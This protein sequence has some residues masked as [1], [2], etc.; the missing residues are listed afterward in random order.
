MSS[1]I[2]HA[3]QIN[4]VTL[5]L[6][7][8]ATV[9]ER[10]HWQRQFDQ[11][12]SRVSLHPAL[13]PQAILVVRSLPDPRPGSLLAE[14]SWRGLREWEQAAQTTLNDCWRTAVRPAQSPVPTTANSVWFADPAEWLA[15]LSR[16]LYRGVAGDRWWW[17]TTLR[18]H[19]YYSTIDTLVQLWQASA[20]W[21]PATLHGLLRH[22]PATLTGILGNL[23]PAQASQLLAQVAQVYGCALPAGEPPHLAHS[24]LRAALAPYLPVS[25][26]P[27]IGAFAPE[28]QALLTVC[29]TLPNTAQWL[30][31]A[32][33]PL[34]PAQA[35]PGE[36]PPAPSEPVPPTP[37]DPP[38]AG[39][40][41]P[42]PS[43]AKIVAIQSISLADIDAPAAPLPQ[44]N[45]E[46]PGASGQFLASPPGVAGH[47]IEPVQRLS[48]GDIHVPDTP[49]SKQEAETPQ[50]PVV[51]P[52][53]SPEGFTTP[54]DTTDFF[55]LAPEYPA[56]DLQREAEQ[57]IATAIGGLW[58][59]VNVL[60]ALAWTG[61][62]TTITPWHQLP[63]LAQALLPT[64]PPDPV[65]G[66]LADIA[67]EPAPVEELSQWQQATLAQV[68]LYLAERLEF[69]EAIATYLTEP[70]TL[71]LTRTHVD[72]VFTLDQIRLDVRMAGLDQDPGW[73]P[74]LARVIAFHYE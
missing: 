68:R 3:L 31:A 20:P 43:P 38:D 45:A 30:N 21:L 15:C 27:W 51:F 18:G 61:G 53:P 7:A 19:L 6:G 39:E 46:V 60:V 28:T 58:Y 74:E 48:L 59:L 54:L 9:A 13:P 62:T 26:R 10:Q 35:Q 12:L 5:S 55:P 47:P 49:L 44:Q 56:G 1:A 70:A 69:P 23:T 52:Q 40:I 73:V 11:A 37:A 25:V 41:A 24:F 50:L 34:A 67:G 33:L 71:Y 36:S 32:I 64:A 22:D 72:V 57:G 16:D 8:A 63:A 4:R 65:W 66:L 42:R 29:L 14:N 17:K 2:A